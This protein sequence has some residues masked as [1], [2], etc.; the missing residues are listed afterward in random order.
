MPEG[1]FGDDLIGVT[2]GVV[3]EGGEETSY[4]RHVFHKLCDMYTQS[5][6]L[7]LQDIFFWFLC[8]AGIFF[9]FVPCVNF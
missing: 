1:I 8:N 4:Y 7:S 2:G 5:Y 6:Q 3:G 9:P